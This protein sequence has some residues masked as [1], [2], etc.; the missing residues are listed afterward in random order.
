M[1]NN[2]PPL[3]RGMRVADTRSGSVGTVART[4]GSGT[5]IT[6][7]YDDLMYTRGLRSWFVPV[8]EETDSNG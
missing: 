3:L 6:V 1:P 8:L 2:S 7:R 5:L 4:T